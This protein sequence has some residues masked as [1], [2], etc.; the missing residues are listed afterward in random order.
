MHISTSCIATPTLK[1]EVDNGAYDS[2]TAL[3]Q[4]NTFLFKLTHTPKEGGFTQ[5]II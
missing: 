4:D 3:Q 2:L 5:H 1:L